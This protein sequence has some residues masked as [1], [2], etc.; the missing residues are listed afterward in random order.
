MQCDVSG[1]CRLV[2]HPSP[3]W[4]SLNS[5]GLKIHKFVLPV[6]YT[7]CPSMRNSFGLQ[8]LG[9]VLIFTSFFGSRPS[10]VEI[11][12]AM[13]ASSVTLLSPGAPPSSITTSV[14]LFI[15]VAAGVVEVITII[16]S[17]AVAPEVSI[18]GWTVVNL[19]TPS[20]VQ[21]KCIVKLFWIYQN[22][23]FEI[24]F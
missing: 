16:S 18:G 23:I 14:V 22:R 1:Q 4:R 8:R 11:G 24:R 7:Q 17:A 20:R 13:M 21:L 6:T 5:D 3:I 2:T 12:V 10:T 9:L 15:D 19:S